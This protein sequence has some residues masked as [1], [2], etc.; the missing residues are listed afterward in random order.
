V[1]ADVSGSVCVD[2]AGNNNSAATQFPMSALKKWYLAGAIPAANC[3]VAYQ[4]VG[5][6][7]LAASKVN[8]ANPGTNNAAAGTNPTFN[9]ATGWTFAAASGQ[10]LTTGY[11]PPTQVTRSA[12]VRISGATI[13]A[14]LRF[15]FSSRNSGVIFGIRNTDSASKAN[16]INGTSTFSHSTN[17]ASGVLAFAGLDPYLN[18]TDIGNITAGTYDQ[19]GVG[20]DIGRLTTGGQHFDGN[21]QAFALY[22]ITLTPTQ[23]TALTTAMNALP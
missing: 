20:V 15:I 9:A 1:T 11:V 21:M 2:A 19:G 16:Y 13:D 3:K 14:A 12:I 10:Y 23:I 8:L 4:P 18:A 7:D 22:D 6:A 17:V 5:A